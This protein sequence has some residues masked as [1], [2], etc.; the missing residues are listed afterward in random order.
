MLVICEDCAKKYD[1][2]E[3]RIKGAKAKF[4][5]RA[6]GHIIVVEKPKIS[7]ESLF[8]SNK[9]FAEHT[10]DTTDTPDSAEQGDE[11]QTQTKH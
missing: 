9:V 5:C 6:C 1:I 2:E 8:E 4:S 10:D 11:R 7:A 3:S